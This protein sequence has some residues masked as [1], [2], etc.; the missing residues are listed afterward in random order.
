MTDE[1]IKQLVKDT[2][3]EVAKSNETIK[4]TVG[5]V[6]KA[7][8]EE[9]IQPLRDELEA[10]K[11][12]AQSQL[13]DTG[14]QGDQ[15]DQDDPSNQGDSSDGS[16]DGDQGNSPDD[17]SQKND[18]L[19]AF[20]TE[21]MDQLDALNKKL[22]VDSAALKGQDGGEDDDNKPPARETKRIERD[23]YGRRLQSIS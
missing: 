14:D 12:Q 8:V 4:S 21:V 16:D 11:A 7:A 23:L 1:E 10:V 2:V 20:K 15:G 3:D 22:G 18:E 9:V 13:S 6:A 5:E 17:S 19:E